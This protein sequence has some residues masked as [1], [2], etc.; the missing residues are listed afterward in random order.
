MNKFITEN[1]RKG[2]K[3]VLAAT[4]KLEF[5]DKKSYLSANHGKSL[6]LRWINFS[7]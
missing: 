7:L 4:P 3:I 5:E 2:K 6:T 1:K